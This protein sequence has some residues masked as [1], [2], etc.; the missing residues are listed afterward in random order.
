MNERFTKIKEWSKEN[1]DVIFTSAMFVGI[2]G[3]SIWAAKQYNKELLAVNEYNAERSNAIQEAIARGDQ[4]LPNDQGG[5]WI[6][7]RSQ[8]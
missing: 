1:A 8:S 7:P 6:I 2:V 3:V 4:L 5:Y